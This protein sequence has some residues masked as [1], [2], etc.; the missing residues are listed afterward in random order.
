LTWNVWFG[1]TGLTA[2]VTNIL[3]I[4]QHYSPTVVCFQEVTFR[5]IELIKNDEFFANNYHFSD[6]GTQQTFSRYGVLLLWKKALPVL[7]L[8]VIPFR[9]TRMDRKLVVL[10]TAINGFTVRLS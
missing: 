9:A 10:H 5:F 6:D 1:S 7:N 4:V 2:R 8:Q 3:E